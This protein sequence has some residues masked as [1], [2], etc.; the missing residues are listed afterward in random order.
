MLVVRSTENCAQLIRNIVLQRLE[1]ELDEAKEGLF[2][3]EK[4]SGC[5]FRVMTK[6]SMLTNT[7]WN[8]YLDPAE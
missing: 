2:L 7:F 1:F 5:I 3:R 8:F 4:I 6:D